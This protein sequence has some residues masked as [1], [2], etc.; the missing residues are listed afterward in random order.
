MEIERNTRG[1]QNL[2]NEEYT[3]TKKLQESPTFI[4]NIIIL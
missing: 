4:E 1:G 3:S 2:C